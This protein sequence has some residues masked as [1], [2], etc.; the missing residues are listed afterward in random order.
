MGK[1]IAVLAD[2]GG[3][4]IRTGAVP[5]G[6]PMQLAKGQRVV[7]APDGKAKGGEIPI[8]F[9]DLARDLKPGAVLLIDDGNISVKV[10]GVRGSRIEAKV[11]D[12]GPLKDHKGIN[13][14][15]LVLSTSALTKKDE[16]DLRF[17][18]SIGVDMIG[19]SF[20]QSARDIAKARSI[21]RRAR[22]EVPIVAKIERQIA[23]KRLDEIVTA[24]DAAMVARGDLGVEIPLEQVPVV[25]K[26]IIS[27]C[28]RQ[29]KP[30]VVATQMMESM[31]HNPRPTRAET[32]DVSNAV[33]EGTD[34]VMLSAETSIGVDPVNAVK[35]MA[36][37]VIRNIKVTPTPISVVT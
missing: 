17:A 27:I 22:R 9:P 29:R 5:G 30:V 4:K 34:A 12:G 13:L 33:F 6:Q 21:M 14:P 19:L 37:I 2:M 35:T 28:A 31:I 18:L 11:V 25:Q 32:T 26:E 24:A 20:V 3:P 23:V 16:R 10:T 15:G 8:S 7:F 1:Y 36:R